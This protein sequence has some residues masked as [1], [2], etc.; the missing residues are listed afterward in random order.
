MLERKSLK[1]LRGLLKL[2]LKE[3]N[4]R[5]KNMTY[6]FFKRLWTIEFRNGVGFD[7][8]FCDSRPVWAVVNGEH[9]VMPFAGTVIL[10][11]FINITI[12]NV[13]EEVDDE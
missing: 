10:L 5:G 13:W 9:D 7:I 2:R 6:N 4:K 3:K 8:E 1:T 11:P 12:G